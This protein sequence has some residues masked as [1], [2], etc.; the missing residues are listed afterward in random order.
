MVQSGEP[1][2]TVRR[3]HFYL[4]HQDQLED[5]EAPRLLVGTP[6]TVCFTAMTMGMIANTRLTNLGGEVKYER[7]TLQITVGKLKRKPG[8]KWSTVK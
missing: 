6:N 4:C 5:F 1:M 2:P 8:G 3:D 7:G